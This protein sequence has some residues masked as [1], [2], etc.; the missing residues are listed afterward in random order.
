MQICDSTPLYMQVISGYPAVLCYSPSERLQPFFDYL[1][2]LGIGTATVA[3]RP[4]LLG[5]E[6]T[7]SLQRIVS[8]LTEV[9]G[10]SQE[11]IAA[12]LDTI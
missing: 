4:T 6:V 3:Q 5:L 2:E 1:K 12:L 8:Y 11:E 10:K 7:S 9:D